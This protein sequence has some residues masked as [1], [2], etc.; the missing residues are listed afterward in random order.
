[1]KLGARVVSFHR[2]F[3]GELKD[4]FSAGLGSDRF[5]VRWGIDDAPPRSDDADRATLLSVGSFEEPV[6]L[7]AAGSA[8][9]AE[10]P[11]NI[12]AIRQRDRALAIEWRDAFAA[13]VGSKVAGGAHITGFSGEGAYVIDA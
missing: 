7:D 2:D 3:Y 11:R 13:T 4:A 6:V 1:M 10:I 9:L 5:L 12:V 8:L